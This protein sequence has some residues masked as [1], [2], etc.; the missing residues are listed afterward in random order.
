[1]DY[2]QISNFLD[3]FKKII[4]QKE[5][6]RLIISNIIKEEISYNINPLNI[7]IKNAIIYLDVSPLIRG[8]ILM[9]KE[10]IL[11][12]SRKLIPNINFCDI[13]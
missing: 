2:N 9:H 5:E 8:E 3:K 6:S 4:F 7:K 10:N 11:L 12:K 1:M 13:K